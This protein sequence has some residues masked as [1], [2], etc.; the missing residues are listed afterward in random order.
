MLQTGLSK[1]L[2]NT[3]AAWT[4]QKWKKNKRLNIVGLA[5]GGFDYRNSRT[6]GWKG[7]REPPQVSVDG[8]G[9][10]CVCVCAKGKDKARLQKNYS[11]K[12]SYM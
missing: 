1:M 9:V 7:E 12:S 6:A 8:D 10:A 5:S 3:T 2:T 11:A 4:K